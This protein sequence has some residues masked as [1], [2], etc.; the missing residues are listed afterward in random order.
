MEMKNTNKPILLL[1]FEELIKTGCWPTVPLRRVHNGQYYW[2]IPKVNFEKQI[3]E[4][5]FCDKNGII[6]EQ[7]W[8]QCGLDYEEF[9]D[10]YNVVTGQ[11][12]IILPF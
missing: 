9:K 8:F 12:Q 3:I 6:S 7:T 2:Y 1:W 10:L 4:V 5:Y 11:K